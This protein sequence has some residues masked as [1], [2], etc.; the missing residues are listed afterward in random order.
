[1]K[2]VLAIGMRGNGSSPDATFKTLIA[3]DTHLAL[4]DVTLHPRLSVTSEVLPPCCLQLPVYLAGIALRRIA[5]LSQSPNSCDHFS[6]PQCDIG[7]PIN[8][9]LNELYETSLQ[10]DSVY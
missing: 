7:T 9:S 8:S 6:V 10:T 4:L 2:V 1:M 5:G 3:L